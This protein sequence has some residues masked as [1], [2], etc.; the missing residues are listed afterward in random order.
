M[1]SARGGSLRVRRLSE[2][3][4]RVFL[5]GSSMVPGGFLEV[6]GGFLDVPG[7]FLEVRGGSWRIHR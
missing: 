7:G 3:V 6:P 4:P 1:L 2:R 5:E